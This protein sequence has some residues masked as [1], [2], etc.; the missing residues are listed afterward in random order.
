MRYCWFEAVRLG[1][2]VQQSERVRRNGR[3]QP[4]D[5]LN[6][7]LGV[8]LGVLPDDRLSVLLGVQYVAVQLPLCSLQYAVEQ[9]TV[10][11]QFSH[12]APQMELLAAEA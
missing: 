6:V 11:S 12:G 8:L 5:R 4:D 10:A 2:L 3:V 1:V 9:S 7:L